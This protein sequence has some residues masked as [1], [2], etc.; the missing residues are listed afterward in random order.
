MAD[1]KVSS[2]TGE[3]VFTMSNSGAFPDNQEASEG[4]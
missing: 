3:V 4:L 2:A 1:F